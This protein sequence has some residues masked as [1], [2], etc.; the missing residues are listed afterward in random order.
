M[1]ITHAWRG[2]TSLSCLRYSSRESCH[3]FRYNRG[4][5]VEVLV[6]HNSILAQS[7]SSPFFTK[8]GR[9]VIAYTNYFVLAHKFRLVIPSLE[10]KI[11][12]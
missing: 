3:F 6:T 11:V 10:I 9:Y 5:L 4:Q 1:L 7:D 8:Q 2:R 12:R